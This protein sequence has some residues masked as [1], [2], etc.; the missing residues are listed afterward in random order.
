MKQINNEKGFSLIELMIVVAIIGILAAVAI[1]NFQTF[2]RRSKQAD[3]K[4]NLTTVYA[5]QRTFFDEWSYYDGRFGHIGYQPEGDLTYEIVTVAGTA[6]AGSL[7]AARKGTA[8]SAKTGADT[9]SATAYCA[10][11][12]ATKCN[13]KAESQAPG[14]CAAAVTTSGNTST[15]VACAAADLGGE[16]PDEWSMDQGKVMTQVSVGE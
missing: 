15:F 1:P 14:T 7:Y 2:I 8:V 5:G 11:V 16:N 13:M 9:V 3:A 4:T 6:P 10:A 12:G